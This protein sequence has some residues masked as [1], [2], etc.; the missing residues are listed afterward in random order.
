MEFIEPVDL[1]KRHH[2]VVVGLRSIKWIE[3]RLSNDEMSIDYALNFCVHGRY[4]GKP[5]AAAER[6]GGNCGCETEEWI[7]ED[8]LPSNAKQ[9]LG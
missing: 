2:P 1:N 5:R 7:I 9:F 3:Q 4:V 8:G 6:A